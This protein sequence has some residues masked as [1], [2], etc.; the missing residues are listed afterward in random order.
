M[1][2]SLKGIPQCLANKIGIMLANQASKTSKTRFISW[3]ILLVF[4]HLVTQCLGKIASYAHQLN[5]VH[6]YLQFVSTR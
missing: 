5:L 6:L 4:Q 1:I 3:L 2:V